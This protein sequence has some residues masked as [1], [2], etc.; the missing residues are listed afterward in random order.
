MALLLRHHHHHHHTTIVSPSHQVALSSIGKFLL[1]GF[2]RP[3]C[4]LFCHLAEHPTRLPM[5]ELAVRECDDAALLFPAGRGM[6]W[7]VLSGPRPRL[8][9]IHGLLQNFGGACVAKWV[10]EDDDKLVLCP[11]EDGEV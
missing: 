11:A 1:Y 8:A 4:E 10:P 5:E 9:P 3:S 6:S 2:I 7:D